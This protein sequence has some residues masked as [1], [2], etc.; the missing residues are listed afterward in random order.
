MSA[1]HEFYLDR[2]AEARAGASAAT[3][4]NVRERWLRAEVTWT[5][6]AARSE[7][8]EKMRE[9]LIADKAAERAEL[10]L[11]ASS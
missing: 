4:S 5:E 11:S 2:A 6:M 8:G 10:K 7:R 1:Q 9:K 3:L